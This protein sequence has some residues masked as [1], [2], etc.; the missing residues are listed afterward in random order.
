MTCFMDATNSRLNVNERVAQIRSQINMGR[1]QSE[2]LRDRLAGLARDKIPE[3]H[4]AL[5]DRLFSGSHEEAGMLKAIPA[6][7]AKEKPALA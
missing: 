1:A 6:L 4:S 3:L 5:F 2:V 7:K